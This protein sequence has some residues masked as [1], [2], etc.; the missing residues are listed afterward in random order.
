MYDYHTHSN[1]SDDCETSMETMVR[2]A[3]KKG[4]REMAVTDHFD[5]DYPDPDYPFTIDFD[6]YHEKLLYTE[7]RYKNDICVLKGIEIGIQP[8]ATIEKCKKT[9]AAFPYDFIIGSFHCLGGEAIDLIDYS[10]EDI[11]KLVLRNYEN[12]YDCLTKFSDYDVIGH[13]NIIDRYIPYIPEYKQYEDVIA[14]I[15]RLL[16]HN[17]KGLELNTS[18]FR[19]GMKDRTTASKEILELYLDLCKSKQGFAPIITFGSDAHADDLIGYYYN[20]C[21]SYLKSLG[22]RKLALFRNREMRFTD[23]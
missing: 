4:I 11:E 21:V 20:E 2:S 16:I 3:I 14:E 15:L 22:F 8:G 6:K 7:E 18:S 19:Y 13:F 23:L 12:M 10:K 1:F 9:A 17:G 5:P